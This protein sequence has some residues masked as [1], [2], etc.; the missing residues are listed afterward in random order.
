MHPLFQEDMLSISKCWC[1][2]HKFQLGTEATRD[3]Y[4]GFKKII[5]RIAYEGKNAL[6]C[7]GFL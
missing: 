1:S 6:K 5:I 4:K 7:S 3:E 2:R